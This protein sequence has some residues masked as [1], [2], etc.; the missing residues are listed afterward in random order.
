MK[1]T[2]TKHGGLA[3]GIRRRPR[4]VDAD[5]L[6]APAAGELSRLVAAAKAGPSPETSGPGRAR[7]AMGYTITVEDGGQPTVLRQSDA[8]MSPEFAALLEWI[9][10][11]P[12]E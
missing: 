6:P 10:R 3:A 12:A 7:D 8:T 2:L 4:V 5:T 9:E 1:V 11:H